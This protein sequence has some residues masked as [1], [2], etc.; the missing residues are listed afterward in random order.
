MKLDFMLVI[1]DFNARYIQLKDNL[2]HSGSLK[3]DRVHYIQLQVTAIY[4]STL[5]VNIRHDFREV[6][7]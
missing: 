2:K 1:I 7:R 4:R 6:V 3:G 5:E